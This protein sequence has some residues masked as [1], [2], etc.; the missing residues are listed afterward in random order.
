MANRHDLRLTALA[1]FT[2]AGRVPS[3]RYLK[4][5]AIQVSPSSST[6]A[7]IS[8]AIMDFSFNSSTNTCLLKCVKLAEAILLSA[9]AF[10]FSLLGICLIENAVKLFKDASINKIYGSWSSSST[11]IKVSEESSYGRSTIKSANICPLTDTL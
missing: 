10:L 11:S 1:F 8:T 7:N 2:S 4:I 6:T 3:S 9:S 5:R